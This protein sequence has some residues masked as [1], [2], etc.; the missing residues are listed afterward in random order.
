MATNPKY[1]IQGNPSDR[2]PI[3][4]LPL[5]NIGASYMATFSIPRFTIGFSV[6]LFSTSL[7][8]NVQTAS[9][10]SSPPLEQHQP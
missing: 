4:F 1:T 2:N 7:V 10:L 9:E 5:G 6:W 3:P 8:M